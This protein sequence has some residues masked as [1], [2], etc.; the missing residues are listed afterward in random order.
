[1]SELVDLAVVGM[2]SAIP[3]ALLIETERRYVKIHGDNEF[4]S[5][6][7]ATIAVLVCYFVIG[8]I[9]DE[10]PELLRQEFVNYELQAIGLVLVSAWVLVHV[11]VTDWNLEPPSVEHPYEMLVL[12]GGGALLLPF[13]LAS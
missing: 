12:L 6:G 9:V 8:T 13:L 7:V 2:L 10:V 3:T 5:K 11:L 1:M 4:K